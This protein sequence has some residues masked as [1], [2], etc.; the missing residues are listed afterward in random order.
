MDISKKRLETISRKIIR[1]AGKIYGMSPQRVC[2]L[3]E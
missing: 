1:L 2:G 3:S